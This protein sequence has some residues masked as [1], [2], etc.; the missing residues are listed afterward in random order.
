MKLSVD[1]ST[2]GTGYGVS[3]IDPDPN[4]LDE[5]NADPNY[6]D[7]GHP[8]STRFGFEWF[9]CGLIRMRMIRLARYATPH[10]SWTAFIR[11]TGNKKNPCVGHTRCRAY[12]SVCVYACECVSIV[13]K[14]NKRTNKR[15]QQ[16]NLNEYFVFNS[17]CRS[18]GNYS[19]FASNNKYLSKF[20]N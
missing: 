13:K 16:Q 6:L 5:D 17:F 14:R 10:R 9:R 18:F 4:V 20:F 15:Q 3:R 11:F 8:D 7:S 12:V 19:T 1:A 2:I